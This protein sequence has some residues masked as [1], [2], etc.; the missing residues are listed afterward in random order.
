MGFEGERRRGEGFWEGVLGLGCFEPFRR[1]MGRAVKIK[2]VRVEDM[3][4]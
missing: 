4:W 3:G 1:G 2:P